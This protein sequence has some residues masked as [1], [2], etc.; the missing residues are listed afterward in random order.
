MEKYIKIRIP[1]STVLVD[2]EAWATEYGISQDKVRDDVK[3]YF[4][5]WAASQ[6]ENLGLG[7]AAN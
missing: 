7:K 4:A 5:Q 3:T 1:A 2:V 6:L